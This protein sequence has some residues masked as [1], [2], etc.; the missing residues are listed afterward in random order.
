[1]SDR[2]LK[3]PKPRGW[4]DV[5]NTNHHWWGHVSEARAAARAAHY[6]YYA[7]NGLVYR[8]TDPLMVEPVCEAEDL[9]R[10]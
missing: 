4:Q 5:F 8:T 2:E 10:A 9:E 7:F 6:P 3:L 1:M